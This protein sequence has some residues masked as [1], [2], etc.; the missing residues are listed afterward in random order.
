MLEK[1]K[2]P[3]QELT[4]PILGQGQS[5][6]YSGALLGGDMGQSPG[7]EHFMI[8]KPCTQQA[9][10]NSTSWEDTVVKL[11]SVSIRFVYWRDE[12]PDLDGGLHPHRQLANRQRFGIVRPFAIFWSD[13]FFFSDFQRAKN[14]K[15]CEIIGNLM[16][17]LEGFFFPKWTENFGWKWSTVYFL[18]M[19]IYIYIRVYIY[20]YVYIYI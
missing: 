7:Y 4:P 11:P 5:S 1:L 18:Y 20:T 14:S 3:I 9:D 12:S 17:G 15:L 16:V 13:V 2:I 6:T 19:Y 8:N 10:K